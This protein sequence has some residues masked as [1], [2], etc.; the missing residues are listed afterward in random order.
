[1]QSIIKRGLAAITEK[2]NRSKDEETNKK[3]NKQ[4]DET[5]VIF[6]CLSNALDIIRYIAIIYMIIFVTFILFY[7]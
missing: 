6:F 4:K 3:P 5:D 7:I 2:C 1:L